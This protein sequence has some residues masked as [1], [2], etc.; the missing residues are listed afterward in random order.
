M[1]TQQANEF[2]EGLESGAH[3]RVHPALKVVGGPAR[4]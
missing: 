2:L 1:S 3:R 4:Q